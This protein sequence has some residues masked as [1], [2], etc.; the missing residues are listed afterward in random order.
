METENVNTEL[1][2][3]E[4]MKTYRPTEEEFT[5]PLVYIDRLMKVQDAGQYGC[6]KIIPPASFK[7]PLAFD[8]QSDRKLPTRYQIL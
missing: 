6:V 1:T 3:I 5:D 2:E 8:M 4:E 7:P